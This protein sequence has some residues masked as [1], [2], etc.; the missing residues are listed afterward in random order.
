MA[1]VTKS[2]RNVVQKQPPGWAVW[3][4]HARSMT[5]LTRERPATTRGQGPNRLTSCRFLSTDSRHNGGLHRLPA[6]G[7][8][9]VSVYISTKLHRRR[10]NNSS[11]AVQSSDDT[12]TSLDTPRLDTP[13]LS[14]SL[15]Q[16][17]IYNRRAASASAASPPPP[18]LTAVPAASSVR[19]GCRV[20]VSCVVGLGGVPCSVLCCVGCRRVCLGSCARS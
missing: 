3:L 14:L 16:R 17:S 6:V 18:S 2:H 7:G 11:S 9:S 4:Q 12:A 20:V 8:M 10:R 1:S 5:G 15:L 13:T 19:P